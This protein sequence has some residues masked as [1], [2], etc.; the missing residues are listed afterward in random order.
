M[1]SGKVSFRASTD[2]INLAMDKYMTQGLRTDL[3]PTEARCLAGELILVADRVEAI[4]REKEWKDIPVLE[5]ITATVRK[6][7]APELVGRETEIDG[8]PGLEFR[9][10]G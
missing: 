1:L 3:T 10:K 6:F 4:E 7:T 8:E 2:C 9:R 5:P